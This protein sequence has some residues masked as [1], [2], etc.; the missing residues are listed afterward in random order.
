MRQSLPS[1]YFQSTSYHS[2]KAN[3]RQTLFQYKAGWRVATFPAT[4]HS[5]LRVPTVPRNWG[6]GMEAHF[7]RRVAPPTQSE[8]PRPWRVLVFAFGVGY[9]LSL[10]P[11]IYL[12]TFRDNRCAIAH[13]FAKSDNLER[14]GLRSYGRPGA[15]A[16]SHSGTRGTTTTCAG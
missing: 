12:C 10:K 6:P 14:T 11:L 3:A 13:H 8:V 5:T 16:P 4:F 9:P 7:P 1:A 2:S 15:L